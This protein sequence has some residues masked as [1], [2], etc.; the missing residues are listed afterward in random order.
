MEG[1]LLQSFEVTQLLLEAHLRRMERE[2]M[3]T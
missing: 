2:L 1:T 3:G